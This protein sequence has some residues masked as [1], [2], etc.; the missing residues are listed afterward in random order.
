VLS[1]LLVILSG[2]ALVQWAAGFPAILPW[3]VLLVV[4]AIGGGAFVIALLRDDAVEGVTLPTP[5]RA[6]KK[7]RPRGKAKKRITRNAMK[8]RRI[9]KA[10]A[11]FLSHETESANPGAQQVGF[12]G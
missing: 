3:P 1:G 12:F 11:I 2:A 6:L 9:R 4:L 5:Q 7:H 10:G 8:R